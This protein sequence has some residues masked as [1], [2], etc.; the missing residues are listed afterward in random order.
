MAATNEALTGLPATLKTLQHYS[1]ALRLVQDR[2]QSSEALSDSTLRAVISLVI[3]DQLRQQCVNA[4][5][6]LEGLRKMIALRGG[7][8]TLEGN[9]PLLLKICKYVLSRYTLES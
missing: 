3:Q 1:T 4:R 9:R 2:L 6:H 7:L 5:D 8:S